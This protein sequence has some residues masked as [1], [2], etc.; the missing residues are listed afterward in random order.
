MCNITAKS[1]V[2]KAEKDFFIFKYAPGGESE[3][4]PSS[5][6]LLVG[7]PNRGKVLEYP[8]GKTVKS[9]SG[10]GIMGYTNSGFRGMHN[11]Q[12]LLV[13][14]GTKY[15]KGTHDDTPMIAAESVLV[16]S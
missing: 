9:P 13:K 10:P 8:F 15:R 11:Y 14:K 12:T 7:F 1:K 3:Y 6:G 4:R 5:R 2:Y 16:C